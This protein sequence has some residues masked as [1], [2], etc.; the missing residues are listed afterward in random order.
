MEN[1]GLLIQIYLYWTAIS[2]LVSVSLYLDIFDLN[3]PY[4]PPRYDETEL[5]TLVHQIFPSL[6]LFGWTIQ[7]DRNP[8]QNYYVAPN[9]PANKGELGVHYYDTELTLL[10][11]IDSD[12]KL[13]VT[14][15]P[16]QWQ[17]LFHKPKRYSAVSQPFPTD[18]EY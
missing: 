10:E 5:K 9:C 17:G 8:N 6:R 4:P 12:P 2:L 1:I 18:P 15:L 3:D 11:Y 13:R 14:C 7:H 16:K